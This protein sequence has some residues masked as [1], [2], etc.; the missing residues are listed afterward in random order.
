MTKY[1]AV[2]ICEKCP[3]TS[4]DFK[5]GFSKATTVV[6]TRTERAW[7]RTWGEKE[8]RPES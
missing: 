1:Q 2:Y 7:F 3:A 4:H 6:R 8:W 5:H